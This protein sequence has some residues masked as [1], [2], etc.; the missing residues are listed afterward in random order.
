MKNYK[1]YLI[2]DKQKNIV[3]AGLTKNTLKIRFD[4]HVRRRKLNRKEYSIELVQDYL[5]LQ[6]AVILEEMM[7]QQYD[8]LNKGWNKSPKSINGYS[9]SHSEEQKK[10][11]SLERKGKPVSSEHAAKNRVARLGQTNGEHW[12]HVIAQ[13]KSKPVMCVETGIIYKSARQAAKELNLHYPRI[14]E[15]CTGKRKTTGGLHFIFHMK[16]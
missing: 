12:K 5:S 7:I 13:V 8:L 2:R 14:S 6:E 9:N 1:V 4:C 16:Q 15:V 11:W 10:K 3:Y